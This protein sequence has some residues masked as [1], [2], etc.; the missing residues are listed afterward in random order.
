MFWENRGVDVYNASLEDY[1]PAL[2]DALAELQGT[3]AGP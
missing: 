1:V 3:P 2:K